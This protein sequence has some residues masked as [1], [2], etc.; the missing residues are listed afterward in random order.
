MCNNYNSTIAQ[1]PH[2]LP[3]MVK[4]EVHKEI[5]RQVK[6]S[7]NNSAFLY[8]PS[9]NYVF[10]AFTDASGSRVLARRNLKLGGSLKIASC[11]FIAF[12]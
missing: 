12:S 7:R 1:C 10:N 9:A 6:E 2:K 5:A 4:D 8:V 11:G 3:E